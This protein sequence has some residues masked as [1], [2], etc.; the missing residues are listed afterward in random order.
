[1]EEDCKLIP[2]SFVLL[3]EK[4]VFLS[5][6]SASS[7]LRVPQSSGGSPQYSSGMVCECCVHRCTVRELRQY[8]TEAKPVRRRRSA[9]SRR[10]NPQSERSDMSKESVDKFYNLL[11]ELRPYAETF[12]DVLLKSDVTIKIQQL[13]EQKRQSFHSVQGGRS[14]LLSKSERRK[15]KQQRRRNRH[16]KH[17]NQK[18]G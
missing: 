15:L 3:V 18:R 4:D 10:A 13:D 2:N 14:S 11:E 9:A 6:E 12:S 5:Q 16:H 1:M 8:C 7:M 17:R